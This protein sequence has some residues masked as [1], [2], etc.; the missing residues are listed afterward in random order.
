M[1]I[2]GL[3][4]FLAIGEG[5]SSEREGDLNKVFIGTEGRFEIPDAVIYG[6]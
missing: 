4:I 6:G 3:I 1:D 5:V 2:T